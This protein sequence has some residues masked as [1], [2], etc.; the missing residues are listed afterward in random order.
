MRTFDTL[1]ALTAAKGDELGA[2]S[3]LTVTQDRVDEFARATEDHQWIHV[4]VD[5][6]AKGPF[7]HTIAHG[8][9]TLSL[10]PFLASQVFE[11]AVPGPRLNYGLNSV[12]FPTPVPVGSHIRCVCTLLDVEET[13]R[14]HLLTIRNEIEVKQA[15]GLRMP[16]PACVAES[17]VLLPA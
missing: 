15:D 13:P 10:I 4:D 16:K 14:G 8:Y 2:S 6:A 5:R 7:G 3:W 1:E 12:R 9:L 17:L 11:I